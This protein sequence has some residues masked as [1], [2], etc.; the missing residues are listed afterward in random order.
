MN[1]KENVKANAKS[2]IMLLE[3]SAGDKNLTNT[4]CTESHSSLETRQIRGW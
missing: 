4:F 1:P 3:T 2:I